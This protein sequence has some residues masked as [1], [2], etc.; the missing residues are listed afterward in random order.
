MPLYL[1]Y[2][3]IFF[4]KI[5]F[6]VLCISK[7]TICYIDSF[8]SFSEESNVVDPMPFEEITNVLLSYIGLNQI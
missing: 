3:L 1:I 2:F 5:S 6:L 8:S 4:N 7:S